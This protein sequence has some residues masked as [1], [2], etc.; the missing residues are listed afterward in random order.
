MSVY[1]PGSFKAMLNND[2]TQLRRV[3]D[4]I[5][6]LHDLNN[7]VVATATTRHHITG[8]ACALEIHADSEVNVEILPC[9][10]L[11]TLRVEN[12]ENMTLRSSRKTDSKE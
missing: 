11:N 2:G 1:L 3:E 12:W 9:A 8:Q 4:D 10:N 7:D 5:P 6:I